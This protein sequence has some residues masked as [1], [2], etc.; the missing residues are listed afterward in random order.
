MSTGRRSRPGPEE[1]EQHEGWSTEEFS[2]PADL[3]RD[4]RWSWMCTQWRVIAFGAPN[5]FGVY[6]SLF[7]HRVGCCIV[8]GWCRWT[9]VLVFG[10]IFLFFSFRFTRPVVEGNHSLMGG[11]A[12]ALHL[13][14][15]LYFVLFRPL[16]C[17]FLGFRVFLGRWVF[18][19][20]PWGVSRGLG[21]KLWLL[22]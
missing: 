20:T 13:G 12:D 21:T 9:H 5:P 6:Y 7:S 10:G 19:A 16:F 3:H 17:L 18:S 15:V 22:M 8:S 4:G 2:R 14:A 11:S 1:D